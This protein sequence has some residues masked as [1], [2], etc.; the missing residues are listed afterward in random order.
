[1][2]LTGYYTCL[3]PSPAN[4]VLDDS[5]ATFNRPSAPHFGGSWKYEIKPVK[6]ALHVVLGNQQQ[7]QSV[8]VEIEGILN[9]KPLG[10][11]Q[12]PLTWLT[13]IQSHQTFS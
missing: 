2:V 13:Q 9:S 6:M 12:Y 1:M 3:T 10:H 7:K 11:A 5:S 4:P 8:L